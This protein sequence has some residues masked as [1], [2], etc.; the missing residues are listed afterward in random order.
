[1]KNWCIFVSSSAR[2]QR[3]KSVRDA[4][5]EEKKKKEREEEAVEGERKEGKEGRKERGRRKEEGGCRTVHH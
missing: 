4:L 2:N 5:V 3:P 1:M